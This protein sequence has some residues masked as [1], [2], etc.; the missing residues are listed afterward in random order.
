MLWYPKVCH[1]LQLH[2]QSG[3]FSLLQKYKV[4][5]RLGRNTNGHKRIIYKKFSV[6]VGLACY[7]SYQ[8]VDTT[9]KLNGGLISIKREH[10]WIFDHKILYFAALALTTCNNWNSSF[11]KRTE[12]SATKTCWLEV[13]T[14]FK[15]IGDARNTF[16]N[17]QCKL[18][19]NKVML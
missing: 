14:F 6:V 8:K 12:K 5:C 1:K 3:N 13:D 4:L 11:C 7:W 9:T 10:Y 19:Y 15:L 16:N 17:Y 18:I 2:T